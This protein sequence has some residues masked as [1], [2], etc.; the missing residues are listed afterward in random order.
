MLLGEFQ[1][2]DFEFIAFRK[3]IVSITWDQVFLRGITCNWLV[4]LAVY[5]AFASDDII[6][7]IFGIWFPI[8]AFAAL[9]FEHSVANM[10]F[11]PIGIILGKVT[12]YQ[13]IVNNLVPVTLVI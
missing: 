2:L 3:V 5:L 13:F 11:I 6:G 9:G 4:C 8:M 7:K 1:Q 12:W 10:F